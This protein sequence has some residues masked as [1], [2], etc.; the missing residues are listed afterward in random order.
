[1]R[2]RLIGTA[3]GERV[4]IVCVGTVTTK[5]GQAIPN[6]QV[7]EDAEEQENLGF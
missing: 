6:F 7:F 4:R 2:D 5:S 1:L 3:E